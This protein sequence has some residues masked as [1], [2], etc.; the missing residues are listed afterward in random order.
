MD[1][2]EVANAACKHLPD[3]YVAS[4]CMEKGAA[5]VELHAPDGGKLALPDSTDK[6]LVEQVNDAIAV[7]NGFM[8]ELN[9]G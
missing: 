1:I 3:G 5:W 7:A 2:E 6:D 9:D 4:L 8:P